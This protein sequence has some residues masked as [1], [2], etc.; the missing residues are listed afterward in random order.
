[1]VWFQIH[2]KPLGLNSDKFQI[3][4]LDRRIRQFRYTFT[5]LSPLTTYMFC[6]V[7]VFETELYTVHCTNITTNQENHSSTG[8]IR[9]DSKMI[10]GVVTSVFMLLIFGCCV[11]VIRRV[12]KKKDYLEPMYSKDTESLI[13]VIPLESMYQGQTTPAACSSRTSLIQSQ[14]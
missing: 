6:I 1:M 10:V 3:I 12:G 11:L 9:I 5:N 4:P 14:D 13:D 8:I 2:Y 7:Y